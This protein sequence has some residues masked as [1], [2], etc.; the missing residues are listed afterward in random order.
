MS[1]VQERLRVVTLAP[2]EARLLAVDEGTAV[3]EVRRVAFDLGSI[4]VEYRRSVALTDAWYYLS[5]L[6]QA[7]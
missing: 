4:P 5:E 1:Y 6:R 2:A 7:S 3:L